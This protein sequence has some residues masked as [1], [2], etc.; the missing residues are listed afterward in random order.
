MLLFF[1]VRVEQKSQL[2]KLKFS[3]DSY[4]LPALYL[5]TEKFERRNLIDFER[6]EVILV[7]E[8]QLCAVDDLNSENQGLGSL[9]II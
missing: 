2:F 4:V 1:L 7:V 5:A 6:L 9:D 3:L 8:F